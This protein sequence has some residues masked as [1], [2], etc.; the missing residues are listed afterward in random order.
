[1]RQ[2]STPLLPCRVVIEEVSAACNINAL[3]V[4][5]RLLS[6]TL[7][8][9]TPP[10]QTPGPSN[11]EP[12]PIP[13]GPSKTTHLEGPKTVGTFRASMIFVAPNDRNGCYELA[14]GW[15]VSVQGQVLV[16]GLWA[17]LCF[18][19]EHFSVALSH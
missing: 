11:G 19:R 1:M 3:V 9:M 18:V 8:V 12:R 2:G 16:V 7:R 14:H 4:L 6:N 15:L 13:H 17:H 10:T 5:F